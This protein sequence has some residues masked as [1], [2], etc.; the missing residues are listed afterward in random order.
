MIKEKVRTNLSINK[1]AKEKAKEIFSKYGLSLSDA[2]NIFLFQSIYTK[3]IPFKI[4]IPNEETDK[5]IKNVNHGKN[6]EEVTLE[7]LKKEAKQCL[8]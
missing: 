8:K 2:V 6:L 4:E 7:Q 5:A 1:Y 3:G